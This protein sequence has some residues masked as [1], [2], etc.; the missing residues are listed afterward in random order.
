MKQS[1]IRRLRGKLVRLLSSQYIVPVSAII[2][3]NVFLFSA[4]LVHQNI[5]AIRKIRINEFYQQNQLYSSQIENRINDDVNILLHQLS[6][7]LDSRRSEDLNNPEDI[8]RLGEFFSNSVAFKSFSIEKHKGK[9]WEYGEAEPINNSPLQF[10]VLETKLNNSTLAYCFTEAFL[11][12]KMES[13]DL[14]LKL[15]L[16]LSEYFTGFIPDHNYEDTSILVISSTQKILFHQNHDFIYSDF[17]TL[18]SGQN[19]PDQERKF[20]KIVA[21]SMLAWH[22]GLDNF[23]FNKKDKG[24]ENYLIAYQPLSLNIH[25]KHDETDIATLP[26]SSLAFIMPSKSLT[27]GINNIYKRHYIAEATIFACLLLFGLIFANYQQKT[28]YQLKSLVGEQDQILSSLLNDSVDAII[29]VDEENTIQ[30]WNKGAQKIFGYVPEEILGHSIERLI[31]EDMDAQKEINWMDQQIRKKGYLQNYSTHRITK[32]GK[33]ITIDESRSPFQSSDGSWM[34]STSIIKDETERHEI[35][36]RMY[37][38]EKLAS[39]GLL[40]SGVAHEINNPLAIILGFTD[41]LKEKFDKDSPESNDLEMIEYNAN[42]AQKIVRNLLGFSHVSEKH[43]GE[44]IDIA[45]SINMVVKFLKNTK[46][47]KNASIE[48]DIAD[49]L[50]PV[51]GDKREFQQVIMNL[52]NNSLASFNKKEGTISIRAR[53]LEKRWNVVEIID[54]GSGIPQFIHQKIFDPFFTT[55]DVGE[56]TGLGLSLCY[57][58]VKKLGGAILFDSK[59][60]A[61]SKDGKSGTT[62]IIRLPGHQEIIEES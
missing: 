46:L 62:F 36:Q 35:D 51:Q 58:I 10:T 59:T 24:T 45:D 54:N 26:F 17:S 19:S 60:K 53:F 5:Q 52:I 44:F 56:G 2:L 11:F 15:C 38:A 39:I 8:N 57:G 1:L 9:K 23:K 43:E 6:L 41:L 27:H 33:R 32:D 50:P 12:L 31:P 18:T 49:N 37:N 4:I 21:D 7:I 16:D 61:E 20:E 25:T 13:D 42:Q 3:L 30:M 28:S 40:A 47:I 55:K 34:G 14:S 22:D 29:V 48:I